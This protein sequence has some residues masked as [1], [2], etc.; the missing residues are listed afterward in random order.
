M[1]VWQIGD[2]QNSSCSEYP[3]PPSKNVSRSTVL[4]SGISR[5]SCGEVGTT[6]WG[7]RLLGGGYAGSWISSAADGQ[8]LAGKSQTISADTGLSS[9]PEI[10]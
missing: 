3:W 5:S 2:V 6:G 8:Q 1:R 9:L 7:R 10:S 4:K